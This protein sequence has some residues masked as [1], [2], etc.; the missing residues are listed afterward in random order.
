MIYRLF[1]DDKENERSVPR[2]SRSH[3]LDDAP[4]ANLDYTPSR[5]YSQLPT[6]GFESAKS[7]LVSLTGVA[8]AVNHICTFDYLIQ[9]NVSY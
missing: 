5:L 4:T 3:P 8:A 1:K 9:H 6:S 2:S 7:E